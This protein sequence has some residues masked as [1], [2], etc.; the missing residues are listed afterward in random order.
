VVYWLIPILA[1]SIIL[2][3][4]LAL[5][6][7]KPHRP[8]APATYGGPIRYTTPDGRN[9]RIIQKDDG[10]FETMEELD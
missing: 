4:F 8:T 3:L 10:T 6:R 2:L 7:P 5:K 9:M 1:V